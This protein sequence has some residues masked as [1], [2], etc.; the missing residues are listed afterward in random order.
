MLY[1]L[2]I[3][4]EDGKG[5]IEFGKSDENNNNEKG[6]I[7]GIDIKLDTTDDNVRQKSNAMLAKITVYGEI[8]SE[9]TEK[10]ISLFEWAKEQDQ[11]RWYRTVEIEVK[12]SENDVVRSYKFEK[13]FVVDYKEFYKEEKN[14]N[15]NIF[16]L[17]LTKKENNMDNIDTYPY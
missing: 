13:M 7:T 3:T 1:T 16:E 9:V 15:K 6:M 17:V 10:I 8:R 14:D 5:I 2:T 12:S 11:K 4:P